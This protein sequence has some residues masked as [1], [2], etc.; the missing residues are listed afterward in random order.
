[1]A[2]SILGIGLLVFLSLFFTAMFE[3]TRIP[4]VLLL[5]VL[6]LL[7]GPISGLVR[8]DDFGKI[9]G[10]MSTIALVVI[11]FES[12][13]TMD[14]DVLRKMYRA[15]VG[16]TM[17][18]FLGTAAI[19]GVV[20]HYVLHLDVRMSILLGLI[21][22]S[23]S[24]AVVIPLARMLKMREPGLTL[25]ILESGLSD[26]ICIVAVFAML[27]AASAAASIHLPKLFGNILSSLLLAGII[28]VIGAV[29][30]LLV[31]NTVRQL[32]NTG[33]ATF[34]FV[35]IL[36]GVTDMLG[37][38]GAI[39]ALAFGAG[40]TNHDRLPLH[41]MKIFHQRELATITEKDH[42]QFEEVVFL[43]KTFFFVYLGLSIRFDYWI[44][45]GFALAIMSG[46]YLL[47][48]LVVRYTVGS[49]S[50][51]WQ[52]SFMLSIMIPKGLA[53]A[54]LA[55]LPFEQGLPNGELIRDFSYITVVTS[56]LMT[57]L[58]V[59][60]MNNPVG[61]VLAKVAGGP[62]ESKPA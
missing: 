16:L 35:F 22:G 62:A 24:P 60:L 32:P 59:P 1:M 13:T 15:A 51:G 18:T 41:N 14:V 58:L 50:P 25:V 6:G 47:R 9:G 19:V 39:A 52:E 12:G 8:P 4:D 55:S 33:F 36:Y 38:S 28:G 23:V 57:A 56:V 17:A 20:G 10:I 26:T 11:L 2:E 49:M 37:F 27:E 34:A 42:E 44:Y 53:S 21:L 48:A 7:L 3:K 61:R 29:F 40:L 45:A 30:W 31:L 46:A 54:V 5:T 43:L